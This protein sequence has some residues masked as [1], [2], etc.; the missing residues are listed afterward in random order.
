MV[1]DGLNRNTFWNLRKQL[2]L[3]DVHKIIKPPVLF[4]ITEVELNLEA[5][6]VLLD[7]LVIGQLQVGTE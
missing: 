2:L 4:S 3:F 6:P 7:Q 5:Q 1:S